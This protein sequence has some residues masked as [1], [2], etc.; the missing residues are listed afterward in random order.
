MNQNK[1]KCNSIL[2][3]RFPPPSEI[4][5]FFIVMNLKVLVD[6]MVVVVMELEMVALVNMLVVGGHGGGHEGMHPTPER[7]QP[8]E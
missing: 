3:G 1:I 6:D 8:S 7:M 2:D 5:S 4:F